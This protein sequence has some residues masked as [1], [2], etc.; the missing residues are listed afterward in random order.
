LIGGRRA[1]LKGIRDSIV[2]IERFAILLII[3]FGIVNI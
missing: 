1:G 3:S 2:A